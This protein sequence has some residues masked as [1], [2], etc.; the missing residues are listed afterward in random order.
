MDQIKY[1]PESE[2]WQAPQPRKSFSERHALFIKPMI[3]GILILLLLIPMSMVRS[4]IDEREQTAREAGEEV[5]QKWGGPQQVTGPVLTFSYDS[6]DAKGIVTRHQWHT[7]PESLDIRGS[8]DTEVRQRGIYE[9]VV[10]NTPLTLDSRFRLPDFAKMG[11]TPDERSTLKGRL[12]VG[13]SDPRGISEQ[14]TLT[15]DSGDT[16][17]FDPGT[18]ETGSLFSKGVSM[19]L[20]TSYLT[21]HADSLV[22]LPIQLRMRGSESLLFAPLG[23]STTVE[24]KS[25][26]ATPSFTGSFLP[27]T[28]AVTTDGF[29]ATWKTLDMNRNYP[30]S[31][32]GDFSWQEEIDESCFGVELLMPVQQYQKSMR[33][34]KYAFLIIILTFVVSFFVEV[35]QKRNIHP[36]QYLLVG[37]ALCLFYTLLVAL[38]EYTGFTAAYLIAAGM[39]VTLLTLYMQGVLRIRRTAL[40]IGGLLTGLYAYI[41]VLIQLENY[42]LL[43]GS[44]GLFVILSLIMYYSQKINWRGEGK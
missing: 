6:K 11:L 4:L 21:A 37:L 31:L 25:N 14:I 17:T 36:L 24:L 27:D 20:D 22:H 13:I 8:L 43:A 44:I 9:V 29:T 33:S 42:A 7:L 38:S 12:S 26:C 18:P 28:R 15:T 10:Y 23:K 19:A 2:N 34:A 16:L 3:I 5:H 40:T 32:S 39:T 35:I 1:T 41:F 30:Q